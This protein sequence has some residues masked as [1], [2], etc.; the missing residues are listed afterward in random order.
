MNHAPL[1]TAAQLSSRRSISTTKQIWPH[2]E[3]LRL[4][5]ELAPDAVVGD[6][7]HFVIGEDM[8]V[9]ALRS[10]DAQLML[11]V[12]ISPMDKLQIVNCQS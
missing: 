11:L 5:L 7:L 12:E 4:S 2:F 1:L 9:V 6:A 8:N 3:A 10:E